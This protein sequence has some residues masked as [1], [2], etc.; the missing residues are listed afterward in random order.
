MYM[1]YQKKEIGYF[2][3]LI[4]SGDLQKDLTIIQ[5]Y[6]KDVLGYRPEQYNPKIF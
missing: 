3:M 1:D 4:P 6:Y 5:D 2:D